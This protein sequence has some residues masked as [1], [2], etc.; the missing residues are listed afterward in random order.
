MHN[1]P[2]PVAVCLVPVRGSTQRRWLGIIRNHEPGFGGTAFP[3]GYV[4][5]G[6]SIEAGAARELLEETGVDSAEHEWLPFMSTITPENRVLIA[7]LLQRELEETEVAA[8]TVTCREVQGFT[9]IDD[10][11][12]LV[13]PLHDHIRAQLHQRAQPSH[14]KSQPAEAGALHRLLSPGAEGC[15]TD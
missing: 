11:T 5:Q 10:S 12:P 1:N 3:G 6:E 15:R 8:L 2:I 13:F 9:L 4:D 7:C 14:V